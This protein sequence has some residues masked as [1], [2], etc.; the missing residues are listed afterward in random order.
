MTFKNLVDFI[1]SDLL[2]PIILLIVSIAVVSFLWG[3]SKYVLHGGDEAKRT[4]GT[5]IMIYG[6]IALFVMVSVWGF[7]TI[8]VNTFFGEVPLPV[9][10]PL[11]S[12]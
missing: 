10:I 11:I 7:V 9:A 1:I 6:I 5:H 4:E 12:P 2:Q 8:L 3:V